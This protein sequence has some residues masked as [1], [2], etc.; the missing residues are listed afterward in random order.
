MLQLLL[1]SP[2]GH[3]VRLWDCRLLSVPLETLD[4]RNHLGPCSGLDLVLRKS[5]QCTKQL[6]W[7]CIGHGVPE[8]VTLSK[9][10]TAV[11][12][13]FLNLIQVENYRSGSAAPGAKICWCQV[14]PL[15]III[16][17]H[18]VQKLQVMGL[19]PLQNHNDVTDTNNFKIKDHT[20]I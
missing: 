14:D 13:S 5:I 17:L 9:R 7:C 15:K 10:T 6:Q 20:K 11:L 3:F 12:A 19:I 18:Q 16:T 2:R 8:M 4:L 1:G